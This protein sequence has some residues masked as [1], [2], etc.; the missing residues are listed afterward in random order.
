MEI[1]LII[2]SVL[3]AM[4]FIAVRVLKG[5]VWGL[6]TKTLASFTFLAT[7]VYALTVKSNY[8]VLFF[9]ILGLTC[10]LIGDVLLDL[11][12]MYRQDS[13]KYLNAGMLSFGIGHIFYF[14]GIL[15]FFT[16]SNV[17]IPILLSIA[18][19]IIISSIIMIVSKH[20]K[21]N[22]K[23]F[24]G[25]IFSYT[26][27]LTF[28]TSFTIWLSVLNSALFVFA[29]GLLLFWLSDI[30]LSM[31]YFGGK[32]KDSLLCIVNHALYY[33]AQISIVAFLLFSL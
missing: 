3:L 23:G 11:K 1:F 2:L 24:Y 4:F 5:G 21:L 12:V 28:L 26:L 9:V 29:V 7:G 17:I 18:I 13:K 30:V 33:S 31:M 22:F 27:L 6:L 15:V 32:E 20:L 16:P 8:T 14:I 19:S 25:Q 10:G